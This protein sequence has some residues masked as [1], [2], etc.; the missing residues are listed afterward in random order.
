M[1][2]IHSTKYILYNKKIIK[3]FK[4]I[5]L[6]DIHFATS[7]TNDKLNY[8]YN[9]ISNENPNYILIVGDIIDSLD[10]IKKTDEKNR[11]ISW[12]KQL[13]KISPLLISLG[14]HDFAIDKI[15]NKISESEKLL[16]NEINIINNIYVIS[17]NYY[18]DDNI[19]VMGYTQKEK[20]YEYIYQKKLLFNH[21]V[22]NKEEMIN[23]LKLLRKKIN[24]IPKNIISIAMI[25]SPIYLKDSEVT[26]Y[27]NDFDYYISGHMHNGLVPPILYEIW[28]STYGFVSPSK[29]LFVKNERNT[30][31]KKTDKLIVNGPIT[32]LSK[33]S[34][35]FKNLNF[36]FPSYLSIIEFTNNSNYNK[37]KI[38]ITKKYNK[39]KNYHN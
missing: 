16:W 20:Y 39:I 3:D 18:K 5:L 25:H 15:K 10:E 1:R 19:F 33:S 29:K 21:K 35:I 36:I 23:E 38:N 26:K 9:F 30:F 32:S 22:E 31:K 8:L 13:S 4:I 17:D 7:F 34:G 37:E 28:N 14:S 2:Y 6:S 27:I 24:N 11:L 12:L